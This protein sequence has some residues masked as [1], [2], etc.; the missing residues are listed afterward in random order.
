MTAVLEAV[1]KT[2]AR[3]RDR[4]RFGH[5]ARRQP[6]RGMNQTCRRCDRPIEERKA[7]KRSYLVHA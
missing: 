3:R 2:E 5:F 7:Q 1:G 4:D 6:Y